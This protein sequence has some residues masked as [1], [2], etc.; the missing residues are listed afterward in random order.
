MDS[1]RLPRWEKDM[2]KVRKKK[3]DLKRHPGFTGNIGSGEPML[4]IH[5][6]PGSESGKK[7]G[8]FPFLREAPS[9]QK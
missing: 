7:K 4:F 9:S 5:D 6:E 3:R 2:K 8:A 1:R